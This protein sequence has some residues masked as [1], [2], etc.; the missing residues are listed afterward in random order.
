MSY[1]GGMLLSTRRC[2]GMTSDLVGDWKPS[3]QCT[4][5]SYESPSLPCSTSCAP[6]LESVVA[7]TLPL[8]TTSAPCSGAPG[9]LD[10][11]TTTSSAG[12]GGVE[13]PEQPAT[14]K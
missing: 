10:T 4:V 6:P 13:T 8:K 5:T 14:I 3:G 9:S 1:S 7:I 2:S 12:F 11:R